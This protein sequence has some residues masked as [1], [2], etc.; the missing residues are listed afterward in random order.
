MDSTKSITIRDLYPELSPEEIEEAETNLK[1]Y[2]AALLRMAERLRGEGRSISELAVDSPF[3][4][5]GDHR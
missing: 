1:R 4:Q 5:T 3:D 2:V